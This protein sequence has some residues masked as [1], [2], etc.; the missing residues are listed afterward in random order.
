MKKPTKEE[1]ELGL[2]PNKYSKDPFN[3]AKFV[4]DGPQDPLSQEVEKMKLIR[5]QQSEVLGPEAP[6]PTE[7]ERKQIRET[8]IRKM[9]GF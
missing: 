3:T 6:E 4:S 8:M 1:L 5:A 9:R 7:E 2:D